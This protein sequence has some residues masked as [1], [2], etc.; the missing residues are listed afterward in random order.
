M[1]R[2]MIIQNSYIKDQQVIVEPLTENVE[3]KD[4]K[5][6]RIGKIVFGFIEADIKE[7]DSDK[8]VKVSGLPKPFCSFYVHGTIWTEDESASVGLAGKFSD[9]EDGILIGGRVL[10]RLGNYNLMF[11]YVVEGDR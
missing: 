2:R 9:D 4:Y 10:P 5:I 1:S 7:E 8:F 6:E 3:I 11:Y